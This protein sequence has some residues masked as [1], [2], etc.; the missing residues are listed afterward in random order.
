MRAPFF[1]KGEGMLWI[2]GFEVMCYIL[3]A[4]LLVDMIRKRNRAE[5]GLFTTPATRFTS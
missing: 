5:G 2:H 1:K 3:A 4:M